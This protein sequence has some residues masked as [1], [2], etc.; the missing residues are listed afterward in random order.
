MKSEK[1]LKQTAGKRDCEFRELKAV[2]DQKIYI[3]TGNGYC[4]FR[5]SIYV[6]ITRE[7]TVGKRRGAKR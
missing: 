2:K 3:C 4:P 7:I 6:N 1:C 5:E